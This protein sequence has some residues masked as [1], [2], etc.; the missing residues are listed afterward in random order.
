MINL[1]IE[2]RIL[3]K[4]VSEFLFANFTLVFS[5]GEIV[6]DVHIIT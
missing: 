3:H 6:S 4:G 2:N 5:L 1:C